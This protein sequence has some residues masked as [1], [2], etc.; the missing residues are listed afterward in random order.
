M[1]RIPKNS[2]L[3]ALQGTLG[4]ELVFKQYSDKVVV[5]KYP[6]MDHIKPTEPQKVQRNLMKEANA[7]AQGIKRDPVKRAALEKLLL[8]GENV[9]HKAKKQFFEE[10]KR[11]GNR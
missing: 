1:A 10:R 11:A 7:Y 8:P 2:A 5:S 4:K 9:Y 6:D 3:G